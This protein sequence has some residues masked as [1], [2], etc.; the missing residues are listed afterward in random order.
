MRSCQE[1]F[2]GL[3][4]DPARVNQVAAFLPGAMRG[5]N[6]ERHL[7]TYSNMDE[8]RQGLTEAITAYLQG[9]SIAGL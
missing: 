1:A 7:S 6:S 9:A 4:V 3:D 8:A 5:I 2:A